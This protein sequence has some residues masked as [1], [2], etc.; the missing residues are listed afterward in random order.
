MLY[1]I[2]SIT[3]NLF[4]RRKQP[5]CQQKNDSK[6]LGIE[7]PAAA[8]PIGNYV[9]TV[10]TGNVIFTS[11]HGPGRGEGPLYKGQ[12]GIRS[13]NRGRVCLRTAGRD[14]ACSLHSRSA[15]GSLDRVKRVVKVVGFVNSAPT[16]TE[17]PAVVNGVSDLL[18]EV[19]GDNGS[20][21]P[22][23]SRYGTTARQHPR[24]SRIG[25]RNRV[26]VTQIGTEDYTVDFSELMRHCE[27]VSDRSGSAE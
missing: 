10:Q 20:A 2:A 17:Q 5:L 14:Y 12:V 9:T 7:L 23:R 3:S 8:T 19:F 18:V 24:G 1:S 21:R 11:G 13:N 27:R 25:H 16:F 15:L 6:K 26:N 4:P 22:I